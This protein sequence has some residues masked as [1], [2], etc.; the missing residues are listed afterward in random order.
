[1]DRIWVYT[2]V[3]DEEE[4]MPFFMRHYLS[5]AEKVVVQDAGSTDATR[6]ICQHYG[7]EFRGSEPW[8]MDERRRR[9][10]AQQ[11]V[12]EAAGKTQW[13]IAPDADEFVMGDFDRAFA[14]AAR[15][16]CDVLHTL[17]WTMHGTG[18]PQDDGRSQIY[19]LSNLGVNLGGEK[20]IVVRAGGDFLWSSG[21]HFIETQHTRIACPL[22]HLLHYRYMGYEYTKKRNARNYE[23]SVEKLAARTCA[24]DYTGDES[25]AGAEKF[26][27]QGVNAIEAIK[28]MNKYVYASPYAP[29]LD[30]SKMIMP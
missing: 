27:D 20:P 11:F 3:R 15:L 8:G 1:M 10:D 26:K 17:G 9:D 4:L 29:H 7:A 5:I 19:E 28:T 23:R 30:G 16:H 25:A 21:R 24:P 14:D 22:L 6:S 12:H 2:S 13:V 18:L